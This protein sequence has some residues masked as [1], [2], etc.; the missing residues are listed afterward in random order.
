MMTLARIYDVAEGQCGYLTSSDA[1]RLDPPVTATALGKL[2]H[3]GHLRR[4]SHGL[5]R[6]VR[7]PESDLDAYVE[8]V[9]W[10]VGTEGVVL[11]E[12]ALELHDIGAWNPSRIQIGV[13]I[14]W[15]T[16]RV[17]P[18][19]IQ[20][21]RIDP[22]ELPTALFECVRTETV[23]SAFERIVRT[24]YRLDL[25]SDALAQAVDRRQLSARESASLLGRARARWSA[26]V[27][28]R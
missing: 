7:F 8:A 18:P 14:G 4:V 9:L 16:H 24:S 12:S 2:A 15:R 1:Q 27:A 11:G 5:Y 10:P 26:A 28:V 25:L 17:P 21:T 3:A 19:A 13:P 6:L 22:T 20:L 23:Q